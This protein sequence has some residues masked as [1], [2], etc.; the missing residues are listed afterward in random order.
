MV[1]KVFIVCSFLLYLL[2]LIVSLKIIKMQ[3]QDETERTILTVLNEGLI[4][5]KRIIEK[6]DSAFTL[7]HRYFPSK[8]QIC[9]FVVTSQPAPYKMFIYKKGLGI[10]KEIPFN[11]KENTWSVYNTL[12]HVIR[13]ELLTTN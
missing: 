13:T 9:L 8:V 11:N 10:I 12:C 5:F 7:E 2:L 3:N 4:P 1:K 6:N